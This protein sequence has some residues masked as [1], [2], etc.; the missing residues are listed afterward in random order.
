MKSQVSKKP[1][2]FLC[3]ATAQED[4]GIAVSSVEGLGSRPLAFQRQTMGLR[5]YK[6]P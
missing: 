4:L 6:M 3:C 2:G 5:S 1:K